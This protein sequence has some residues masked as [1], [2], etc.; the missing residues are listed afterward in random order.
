MG[1]RVELLLYTAVIPMLT[2]AAVAWLARRGLP[3][4]IAQRYWLG[5]ALAVGFII[6]YWLLPERPPL[7]PVKHWHWLPY[8]AAMALAGGLTSAS[9]ASWI[10][11]LLVYGAVALV[12]AW[13]LVPHW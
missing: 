3:P 8:L 12:A 5:L 13:K 7:A 10:A 9:D 11:R 4:A 6:G 2:A 1:E